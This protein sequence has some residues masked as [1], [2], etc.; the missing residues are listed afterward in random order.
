MEEKLKIYVDD[1]F[2][3][4]PKTKKAYQLKEEITSNLTD[5]YN[6]LVKSDFDLYSNMSSLDKK[7]GE[8]K[9]KNGGNKFNFQVTSGKIILEK[10]K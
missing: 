6:D 3:N 10:K 4:A 9:Y 7:N 8:G 1:I 2:E 5:K